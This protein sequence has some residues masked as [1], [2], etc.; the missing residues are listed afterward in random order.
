MSN[1]YTFGKRLSKLAT[2]L[3]SS[4]TEKFTLSANILMPGT[5]VLGLAALLGCN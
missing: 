2:I 1:V 3:T 4:K 5:R